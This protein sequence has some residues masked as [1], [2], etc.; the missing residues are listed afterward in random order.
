MF[1]SCLSGP[2]VIPTF[3]DWNP[4]HRSQICHRLGGARAA[5]PGHRK[6]VATTPVANLTRPSGWRIAK[7]RRAS[8][9][10][11][12]A[13]HRA[14]RRSYPRVGYAPC[15]GFQ[16]L[17]V[18]ISVSIGGR[19]RAGRNKEIR[20]EPRYNPGALSDGRSSASGL[21]RSKESDFGFPMN[22]TCASQKD[23]HWYFL[24]GLFG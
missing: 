13:P 21:I 6:R 8:H 15:N 24:H 19:V 14:S 9:H 16:S 2:Q 4:L 23:A 10:S 20:Y 11:P 7:P 1:R 17:K 5:V 22:A 12:D 18:G 3:S